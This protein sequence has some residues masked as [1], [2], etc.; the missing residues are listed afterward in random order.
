M[1]TKT[2]K[3]YHWAT[4]KA[5]S[6]HASIWISL[7]FSL[8]IFLFIPLDAILMFFC[9]QNRQKIPYYVSIAAIASVV[10]GCL[11]YFLGHFVWDWIGS[12]IVPHLISFS[13][14]ENIGSHFAQYENWAV[15]LGALLPFPLKA[16]SLAA[17]VFHLPLFPF[18]SCLAAARLLR[19]MIVGSAMAFWGEKVKIFMDKHFHYI[20]LLIG[21]KIA[22]AV[23]FFW[24]MAKP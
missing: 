8:E 24:L 10:S 16:I 1:K 21:A 18:I 6:K 3:L 23:G 7:L 14:F 4:E 19:F 11:G 13:L 9:L 20:I 22:L 2:T 12:Y 15:F 5:N 17:G